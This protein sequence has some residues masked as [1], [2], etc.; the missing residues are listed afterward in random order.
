[1]RYWKVSQ[2]LW[3]CIKPLKCSVFP[4]PV[5][6]WTLPYCIACRSNYGRVFLQITNVC[7]TTDTN[8]LRPFTTTDTQHRMFSLQSS[9]AFSNVNISSLKIWQNFSTALLNRHGPL[10][11]NNLQNPVWCSWTATKDCLLSLVEY[12]TQWNNPITQFRTS[13]YVFLRSFRD[14]VWLLPCLF[15][16]FELKQKWEHFVS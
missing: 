10:S 2:T 14:A 15:W 8:I 5:S 3:F 1:M 12:F 16:A 7:A 9:F 13:F 11:R 6:Q 4:I